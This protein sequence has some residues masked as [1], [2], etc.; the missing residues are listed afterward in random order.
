MKIAVTTDSGSGISQQ[1]AKELGITVIPM[2]FSIDEKTYFKDVNIAED[3]FYETLKP[4]ATIHTSQP[5]LYTIEEIWRGLLKEYDA[6]VHIP[7]TSGLS[8]TCQSAIMLASDL[9]EERIQVVDNRK[10]SF[11]QKI[12]V[13]QA[14][15]LIDEGKTASEIKELLEAN[16]DDN[17]IYI[18]LE[19]LDFLKA[20]G[21]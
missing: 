20:G 18:G 16:S 15:K 9:N 2:P 10:V 13:L 4:S 21:R 19:T 7:L 14:L 12:S 5:E 8:S 3:A 17:T 1:E 6:I 11:S